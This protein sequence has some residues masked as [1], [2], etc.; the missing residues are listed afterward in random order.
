MLG[1]DWPDLLFRANPRPVC[2]LQTMYRAVAK[3]SANTW[4]NHGIPV[5]I[6]ASIP[7]APSRCRTSSEW[8]RVEFRKPQASVRMRRL[9]PLTFLPR[10]KPDILLP[11]IVFTNWL[12]ITSAL[13]ETSCMSAARCRP[14]RLAGATKRAA[15]PT[16]QL[17]SA[18]LVSESASPRHHSL[19]L[20]AACE[21]CSCNANCLL[22][23]GQCLVATILM[24]S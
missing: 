20:F 22:R 6:A 2:N 3:I 5:R 21:A 10:S 11:S 16:Q 19:H 23:D 1:A 12:S 18:M 13:G 8:T 15:S 14:P 24:I 4:R 17:L 7:T 9:R